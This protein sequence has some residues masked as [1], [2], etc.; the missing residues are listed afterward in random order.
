MN[1]RLMRAGLISPDMMISDPVVADSV[2]SD[3]MVFD[4]MSLQSYYTKVKI[5]IQ[6]SR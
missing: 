3:S 4:L 2:I 1:L 5:R 6:V